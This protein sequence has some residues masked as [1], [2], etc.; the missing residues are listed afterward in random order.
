MARRKPL[1]LPL[2]PEI[3]P[4]LGPGSKDNAVYDLLSPNDKP[5]LRVPVGWVVKLN[6][7]RMPPEMKTTL[8]GVEPLV[9][10]ER[11]I[12]YKKNKYDILKLFLGPYIPQSFFVLTKEGSPDNERYVE[13]TLQKKVPNYSLS[14]LTES[15]RSDPRLINNLRDLMLRMRMMYRVLGEV[16]A[17]MGQGESLDA[18]L[19]L[20][21]VSS[22]ARVENFDESVS[23][24]AIREIIKTNKS[25]NLLINPETMALYCVDFDQGQWTDGM[26]RAKEAVFQIFGRI[27]NE[28][29]LSPV[30]GGMALKQR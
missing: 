27:Q 11:G 4:L 5:H 13:M 2:A 28:A 26:G 15:Q 10:A 18:K 16:N 19:D 9:V 7:K 21:T 14:D 1:N 22:V 17:R 30:I 6:H 8:K 24:D 29:I 20:G 3:G 25:P 23:D 12:Q